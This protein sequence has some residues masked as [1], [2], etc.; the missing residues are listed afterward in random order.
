MKSIKNILGAASMMALALS[1]TSCT[2]GN[3][4]D[5]DSSLSRLF[6]VNSDKITVETTMTTA[7]VT[8]T[9]YTS[10]EVAEPEYYLF[11]VSKDSLYEGVENANIVTYGEDKSLT[12][13][14]VVLTGLDN[15][16][17][18]YMR[19][20]SVSST[21]N[22]SKWVYYKKG[23]S[24]KTKAEQIF[25]AVAASDLFDDHVKLSWTPGAEVTHI[26]IAQSGT[27]AKKKIELSDEIK[28][29]GKA[30]VTGLTGNTTYVIT[31]YNN[32]VKRGQLTITTAAPM[33]TADYK[34]TLGDDVTEINQDLI[35]GIAEQAKAAAGNETNYSATIG[36]KADSELAFGSVVI[37]EGMSVTFFGLA[38]GNAPTLKFAKALGIDGTH[39]YIKFQNV[40][41]AD[42]GAGYFINQKNACTIGELSIE[43]CKV[44]NFKTTV[45]RMQKG[46]EMTI[47]NL[48]LT[49]SI[50]TKCG[51]GYAFIH[52]DAN[53]L[54]KYDNIKIDKCTFNTVCATGKHFIYSKDT[55]STS[56]AIS[57]STFY[58]VNGGGQFFIDFNKDTIGPNSLSIVNCIFS[59]QPDEVTNKNIRCSATPEISGCYATNDWFKAFSGLT[60]LD[61]SSAD[62]FT[63][64]AN[65]DF[66]IK[67]GT[68]TEK[69]GDPRW[70]PAED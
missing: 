65:G 18:Y 20:K 16:S 66:T 39:S 19:V 40:N 11:E 50:F 62:L 47:S 5:V 56:I 9:A 35:D 46:G 27:D 59:K 14:P 10:K 29:E 69:A 6:G 53:K 44:D 31:I 67:N 22:E 45:F 61:Y 49:N 63:D 23:Q 13:S 34:L 32:D 58:N 26:T 68:L 12:S 28:Q 38:G 1:A 33:P 57:N 8:F 60:T 21:A 7:T 48:V 41:L 15:D 70:Y 4:W 37:P 64:P 3:D 51:A 36:I 2:D 17:K 43:D 55:P 30:V 24:F 54:G 52:A 42:N 25:N